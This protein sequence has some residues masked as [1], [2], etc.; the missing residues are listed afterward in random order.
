MENSRKRVSSPDASKVS[1]KVCRQLSPKRYLSPEPTIRINFEPP[2]IDKKKSN[3]FDIFDNI[4]KVLF[5]FL[6]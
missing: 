5:K 2:K 6:N 4:T 1:K 3:N